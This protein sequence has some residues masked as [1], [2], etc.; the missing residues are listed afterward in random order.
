M[1]QAHPAHVT[2]AWYDDSVGHYEGDTLVID[3]VGIV[4]PFGATDLH[5]AVDQFGTPHGPAMHVIERYRFLGE[6]ERRPREPFCNEKIGGNICQHGS[7]WS[8]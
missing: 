3:T 2:P 5:A 7:N 1:N 6:R 4:G 8:A